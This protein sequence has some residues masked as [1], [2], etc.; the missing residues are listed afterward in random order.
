[1]TMAKLKRSITVKFDEDQIKLL[2]SAA[3][4][5]GMT[6]SA[7]VRSSAIMRST[8]KLLLSSSETMRREEYFRSKGI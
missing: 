3:E 6:L 5:H 1:M 7:Y 8:G 2:I 4:E